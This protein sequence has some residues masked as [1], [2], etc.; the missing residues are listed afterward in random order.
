N[1]SFQ[2]FYGE[3]HPWTIEVPLKN[4]Y[5]PKVLESVSIALS[6]YRYHNEFDWAESRNKG[7][8]KAIIYNNTNNSAQLHIDYSDR[9]VDRKYPIKIDN[10]N[11]RIKATHTKG[12]VHFNY[13]FNRVKDQDNNVPIWNW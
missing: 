8:N 3:K 13:L 1:K 7:I 5:S 12:Y 10:T 6:T 2:V 4:E 9:L 11:Q